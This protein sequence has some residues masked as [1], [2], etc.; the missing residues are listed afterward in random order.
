MRPCFLVPRLT[1]SKGHGLTQE[2][3]HPFR[4]KTTNK[5]HQLPSS[6]RPGYRGPTPLSF[7]L[8]AD[9]ESIANGI[10]IRRAR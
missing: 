5:D 9:S 3:N 7:R 4:F 1:E 6:P 10:R 2:G 8:E